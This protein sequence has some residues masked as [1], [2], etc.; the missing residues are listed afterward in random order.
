LL[1]D[2][3][4]QGSAAAI[5]RLSVTSAHSRVPLGL[6]SELIRWHKAD[7]LNATGA[8]APRDYLNV[9]DEFWEP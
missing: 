3:Q 2:R 4:I 7:L 9:V 5:G 6:A 1:C 8:I